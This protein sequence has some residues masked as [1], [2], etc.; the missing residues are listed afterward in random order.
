[1]RSLGLALLILLVAAAPAAAT[2]SAP[3]R[4][5]PEG[6]RAALPL[7]GFGTDGAAQV[8]W[9]GTQAGFAADPFDAPRTTA[10]A[11]PSDAGALDPRGGEW[12][13]AA[14]ARPGGDRIELVHVD[15]DARVI[16]RVLVSPRGVTAR[17]PALAVNARGDVLAA[18]EAIGRS[19]RRVIE[20]ARR[21]HGGRWRVADVSRRGPAQS[22]AVALDDSGAGIVAFRRGRYVRV[23]A[24]S[25]RGWGY[26]RAVGPAGPSGALTVSAAIASSGAAA[27][28]WA[29]HP[30]TRSDPAMTSKVFVARRGPGAPFT[31]RQTRILD[32]NGSPE[33][34]GVAV[35]VGDDGAT[36]AGWVGMTSFAPRV[37]V[38]YAPAGREWRLKVEAARANA[39]R[40]AVA[41]AGGRAYV[42]WS[43]D[44]LGATDG[45]VGGPYAGPVIIDCHTRLPL[46][47]A[48]DEHGAVLAY[49]RDSAGGSS[50]LDVARDLPG[51]TP[52][53]APCP[54]A[55]APH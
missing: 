34:A 31:D 13:A 16:E 46:A 39:R 41:M 54:R 29:Q 22:P 50:D 48:A 3:A 6:A 19:G 28:I 1:M 36:L 40:V 42:A 27:V 26:P 33:A 5:S 14:V 32:L 52:P 38:A 18:W 45:A 21:R 9:G 12:L 4:V 7:A 51:Q 11:H 49:L 24:L 55:P 10:L 47:L 23:A 37:W 35:A 20:A 43:G 15:R 30:A 25:A 8:G 44:A 17:H 2:W 53:D